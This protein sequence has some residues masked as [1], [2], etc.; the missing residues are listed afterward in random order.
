VIE[1]IDAGG[2]LLHIEKM[3]MVT[4]DL[5]KLT[6]D[7]YYIEVSDGVNKVIP[8]LNVKK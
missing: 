7:V 5:S 8:P 6:L 4:P 1:G 3:K 2:K